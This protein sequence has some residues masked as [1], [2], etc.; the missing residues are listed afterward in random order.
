MGDL[1][2][3]LQMA[4]LVVE[5]TLMPKSFARTQRERARRRVSMRM[6]Y[7]MIVACVVTVGM[8]VKGTMNPVGRGRLSG[9]PLLIL[10]SCL[11]TYFW[12]R[13]T[14]KSMDGESNR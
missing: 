5:E 6:L 13:K 3:K 12:G 7:A 8:F 1:N 2:D 11:W 4:A 9:P 10:A 14:L